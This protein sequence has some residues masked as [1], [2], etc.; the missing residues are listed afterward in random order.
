VV[1][2]IEIELVPVE[3]GTAAQVIGSGLGGSVSGA[4]VVRI[5][6]GLDALSLLYQS[7]AAFIVVLRT[8]E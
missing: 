3:Y 5:N 4:A 7:L 8:R 1:A 6:S 2:V